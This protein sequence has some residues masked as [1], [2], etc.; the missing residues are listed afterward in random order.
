MNY[1]LI[2]GCYNVI[3]YY[4]THQTMYCYEHGKKEVKR[5]CNYC[6]KKSVFRRNNIH[7][8]SCIK[9]SIPSST[10]ILS[11]LHQLSKPSDTCNKN[12]SETTTI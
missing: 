9:K 3:Q 12:S 1:C 11:F 8:Y 10:T 7:C 2:T 4:T 5:I 6:K